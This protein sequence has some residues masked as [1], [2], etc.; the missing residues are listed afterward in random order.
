MIP[1]ET[2]T[3]PGE[4][5]GRSISDDLYYTT[6]PPGMLLTNTL[7]TDVGA[8]EFA[9]QLPALFLFRH[10]IPLIIELLAAA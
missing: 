3:S 6:F 8:L 2:G 5:A 10:I 9:F 7:H 4:Y 1:V